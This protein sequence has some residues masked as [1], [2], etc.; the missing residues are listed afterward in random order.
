EGFP[1]NSD[2][3]MRGVSEIWNPILDFGRRDLMLLYL[4]IERT[5]WDPEPLRGLLNA[6]AFLLQH[7]FY[8]LFFELKQGQAGVEKRSPNLCVPIELKVLP[9]YVFLATQQ[10]RTLNY[11]T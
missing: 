1:R 10:H 2:E 3:A 8:V 9:R 4:L 6:T 5:S 11:V 7:T